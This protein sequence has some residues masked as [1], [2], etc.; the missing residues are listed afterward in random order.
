MLVDRSG[1][2]AGKTI[3][4]LACGGQHSLALCMDGTLAGWGANNGY[5]LGDGTSTMRLSPVVI[6]KNG[7]LA[8]KSIVG[9]AAGSKHSLAWCADGALAAWGDNDSAKLGDGTITARSAAI[10]VNRSGAMANK[11]VV[12]AL[13][14]ASHSVALCA[15]GT[16]AAWGADTG[17]RLGNGVDGSSYSFTP[18]LVKTDTTLSGETVVGLGGGYYHSIALC[19]DGTLAGWGYNSYGQLGIGS[20]SNALSP[21]AVSTA[22]LNAGERFAAVAG[23]ENHTIAL[24]AT[25]PPPV[26][27]T[28]AADSLGDATATLN[29]TVNASGSTATA[30]FEYGLTSSYGFTAI[31]T[32]ASATGATAVPVSLNLTGLLP[33][34]VYHFRVI[35]SG[36]GGVVAGDDR[37]FTTTSL[38]TLVALT[39]EGAALN[40]AFTP[41]VFSYQVTVPFATSAMA[42]TP[43]ASQAGAAIRV[44]GTPVASGTASESQPLAV[45]SN[46]FTVTVTAAGGAPSASYAVEVARLPER[47]VFDSAS[48]VPLVVDGF[49]PGGHAAELVLNFAPTPGTILTMVENTG[50]AAISGAFANLAH[51]QVVNL[52]FNGT[53]FPFVADYFGGTGNDLVLRWANQRLVA[54]GVNTNGNLG[55]GNDATTRGPVAVQDNGVLRGKAVIAVAEGSYH[56]LALCADGTLATWGGNGSA[57]PSLP[58]AVDQTGVLAGKVVTRI[59]AGGDHSLALC[60]DGTLVKWGTG[61]VAPVAVDRSGA[62]AGKTI[63][64]LAAGYAHDLAL[65]EDGT[66]VAWGGNNLGQLGDGTLTTRTAPVLV[67]RSGILAGKTVVAIAAGNSHSLALCSDGVVA[68]WGENAWG[69]LGDNTTITRNTPVRSRSGPLLGKQVT[70]IAAGYAHRLVLCTDGTLAAWGNNA[71]GQLGNGTVS[72]MRTPTLVNRSG[73]LAGQQVLEIRA[74][75]Y[76]SL[77]LCAD[78]SLVG[79]GR[80]DAGQLAGAGTSRNPVVINLG[81]LGNGPV[82]ALSSADVNLALVAAPPPPLAATFA[83]TG[84]LDTG[85]MLNGSAQANGNLGVAISF[86]YGLTTAYGFGVSATPTTLADNAPGAASAQISGLT[87]GATYH[88]RTVVAGPAGLTVGEDQTFTTTTFATLAGLTLSQGELSPAFSGVGNDYQVTVPFGAAQLVLTPTLAHTDSAVTVNGVATASG[89]PSAPVGLT[90]GQSLIPLVVT[91]ADGLNL[92]A[93]TVTVT[94]LPETFG[95]DSPNA[96]PFQADEFTLSGDAPRVSLGFAP[97][98]GTILTLLDNTGTAPL[99]GR[100]S[101]LPQGAQ[102]AVDHG[103]NTYSFVANYFG[104]SGNE[105]VLEWANRRLLAWGDN[106]RGKLGTGG[107][108]DAPAPTPVTMT[109]VLAGKAVIATAMGRD[110]ALALCADGTLAAW[111]DNTYGQLGNGSTDSN[112]PL[113]VLVDASGVLAGKTVVQIA[114]GARQILA[115]CDDGTL[116][117]WGAN[118]SGQLGDGTTTNRSLPVRV[119]QAGVLSGKWITAIG[120]GYDYSMA[121]C[122]DGTLVAWGDNYQGQLGNGG[123][124]Y[125]SSPVQVDLTAAAGQPVVGFA[126]CSTHVLA[127]TADGT[128]LAWGYDS[129]GQLGDGDSGGSQSKAAVVRRTGALVGKTIT[130]VFPGYQSSLVGCAD[131]SLVGWG[132]NTSGQLGTGTAVGEVLV[133]V[134]VDRSGVLAGK[135]VLGIAGGETHTIAWSDDFSVAGWGTNSQGQTGTGQTSNLSPAAVNLSAL[136]DGERMTRVSSTYASNLAISDLPLP[137]VTGLAA[138][139]VTGTGAIVHGTVNAWQNAVNA[140]F[141]FGLD[142]TYGSTATATPAEITGMADTPVS[143]ALTALRPGSTYHYRVVAECFGGVVRSSD[144]T[145]TTLSDNALLAT[146]G[147]DGGVIAP[148]FEKQRFDY[149]SSVPFETAAVTVTAVT[150]HPR[151]TLTVN[152]AVGNDPIPLALG[153]NSIAVVV[154]A[155]DGITTKTYTITVNRLP[156]EFVFNAAADIPLTSDGFAAGGNPVRVVLGFAPTPGTVLMMLNNTGLGFIYGRFGNLAQ[157]Q[158]VSLTNDGKTYDFIA[159]YHGGTGNDLVLQWA[160]TALLAWGGNGFGQLGDNTMTRRLLP[161]PVNDTGLLA[162]KTAVA[163]SGGY[164]HSLALCA[165]GTLAAWGYNAFGQLGNDSAVPSSVPVAVD[166]TGA[167][168]GK[169]V[170]AVAAGPF[171]NLAL[172]SDGTVAAWGYNNYGQLGDGGTVTRR[173]PV[174]VNP[175]GALAGKQ[176]VAVAAGSYYSFALCADGTVAAWGYNDEG[177]LGNGTTTTSLLPVMVNT[178]GA[179]SGKRVAALA[180][181]QYHTLALCTDGTLVSWGYNNRGQ[182]GNN[183]TTNSPQP[184]AIGSFGALAGKT[185]V[186][187]SAGA[188]HSLARCADGTVAAWGANNLGQLGTVGIT[189]SAVPVAVNLAAMSEIAAGGSHSVALGADGTLF[190]WGDNADGQL[191]DNSTTSRATPVAVDFAAISAGIRVMAVAAGSAARHNLAL[192]ALPVGIQRTQAATGNTGLSAADE[193]LREAF[194]LDAGA[195]PQPQREGADFVI[196]FTQ[197]A[198][199]AGIRYGAE[200]SA[201]LQPDSW[202]DVPD[203]GADGEHCFAIPA[204]GLPQGFLRL[205]VTR[206]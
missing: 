15:D 104:G 150:D 18:V 138:T 94:R 23:G 58:V 29:G 204:A 146:L 52:L 88:F 39:A 95:L 140:S 135:T 81:T 14:G 40:P 184:V 123:S 175:V 74:G 71:Y 110:S 111:G 136:I 11:P 59:A 171:H 182:L 67:D 187:I 166:R 56:S 186:G 61:T 139:A 20:T 199:V 160:N 197:P 143:A 177:E 89:M 47:F 141:E 36:P 75:N 64:A 200:W 24:V 105:L 193:L 158:R 6:G 69:Q 148:G 34:T 19:A 155:E 106:D 27:I 170:V 122:A 2:L 91:A 30:A 9:I 38:A 28:L 37:T 5:Q 103:G 124:N 114:I 117:A 102:I 162:D 183:S 35:A 76:H 62:L 188:Y 73:A 152:G 113:P 164:L 77:A 86:E 147:H 178:S 41:A 50:A 49:A 156:Q 120:G 100:F 169:T 157:G 149:L 32:P 168:A 63:T 126:A 84:I 85:A 128:L 191:G 108:G 131:G 195:L 44:N 154:T 83:A 112:S 137:F 10:W 179:L 174:R 116:V 65:C 127:L 43:T 53:S 172:C 189:S 92:R 163:V 134:L 203:T 205:K 132:Y 45:G 82:T 173:A 55:S 72:S 93:Y 96:P 25:L 26:P 17:G 190:A 198:G 97:Q 21:A 87:A 109:G 133:P 57:P 80:D 70:A 12:A 125:R 130:R 22:A 121:L 4:A 118:G 142:E 180:A 7:V 202:Q 194:G 185:P 54:W 16:I 196:R 101:D 1:I 8:G 161:T 60:A 159:N 3:V 99:R 66:L 145:F 90:V 79:W 181:G 167:L 48:S 42:L 144:M 115:L 153:N 129:H 201:T 78:G 31:A 165:D 119:N 176:V 13:G 68:A 107:T 192:V 206:E 51:G 151:A 46:P 98:P 33:G